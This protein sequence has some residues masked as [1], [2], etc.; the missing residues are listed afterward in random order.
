MLKTI[1]QTLIEE[2]IET[3]PRVCLSSVALR[4]ATPTTFRSPNQPPQIKCSAELADES[5]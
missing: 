5:A 3:G 1:T 2:W 4:E